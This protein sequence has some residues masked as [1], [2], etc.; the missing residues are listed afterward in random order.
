MKN[1]ILLI[2]VLFFTSCEKLDILLEEPK[3]SERKEVQLHVQLIEA[4]AIIRIDDKVYTVNSDKGHN[5]EVYVSPSMKSISIIKISYG[6]KITA[7]IH[8]YNK[9]AIYNLGEIKDFASYKL[10]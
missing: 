6:G 2:I 4:S 9:R 1:I 7:A 3:I 5:L 10:D 8:D